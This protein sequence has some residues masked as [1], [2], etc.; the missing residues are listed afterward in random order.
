MIAIVV[1][2][3][4]QEGLRSNDPAEREIAEAAIADDEAL[5]RRLVNDN[6]TEVG[7][8]AGRMLR[9]LEFRGSV[10]SQFLTTYPDLVG[11]SENDWTS[12]YLWMMGRNDVKRMALFAR[13]RRGVE[14]PVELQALV[15]DALQNHIEE[16]LPDLLALLDQPEVA[17]QIYEVL[18]PWKAQA[19]YAE[20]ERR[21]DSDDVGRR[22]QALA[23]VMCRAGYLFDAVAARLRDPDAEVRRLAVLVLAQGGDRRALEAE[24]DQDGSVRR[25]V[26]RATSLLRAEGRVQEVLNAL[27]DDDPETRGEAAQAAALL[28]LAEAYPRL[29]QMLDDGDTRDDAMSAICSMGP[30]LGRVLAGLAAHKDA[31]VAAWAVEVLKGSLQAPDAA[32]LLLHD[33]PQVR[34]AAMEALDRVG[35]GLDP[36]VLEVLARDA[37]RAVRERAMTELI[38]RGLATEQIVRLALASD[39]LEL[40]RYT[41]SMADEEFADL[42]EERV[43]DAS[44]EVRATLLNRDSLDI[45]T[46]VRLAWDGDLRIA[47]NAIDRLQGVDERRAIR[48]VGRMLLDASPERREMAWDESFDADEAAPA[49]LEGF[50]SKDGAVRE[51]AVRAFAHVRNEATRAAL[52]SAFRDPEARV[53]QA[54]KEVAA[55]E[56]SADD[57][58]KALLGDPATRIAALEVMTA[59]DAWEHHEAICALTADGE[60]G[61]RRWVAKALASVDAESSRERLKKLAEDGD[62]GERGWRRRGSTWSWTRGSGASRAARRRGSR[63]RR[64]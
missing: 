58:L 38:E 35:A 53:R 10:G 24:H 59:T 33:N 18:R 41:A 50:R 55:W 9:R 49:I 44:R 25:A 17:S 14:T 46:I 61:V 11:D 3:A 4:L 28:G 1:M 5:L 31:T 26:I 2:L 47:S 62:A 16:A 12:A 51:R 23:I 22:R 54:A 8:R 42:V 29:V 21:L 57:G 27:A 63:G 7:S 34:L 15:T 52:V 64:G 6:D 56:R 39:C 19:L 20:M 37:D 48:E 40:R 60:A 32:R 36:T 45:E 30:C 43:N 13:A